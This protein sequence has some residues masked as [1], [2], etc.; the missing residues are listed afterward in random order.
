MEQRKDTRRLAL[1]EGFALRFDAN[2]RTLQGLALLNISYG[3][4]F[5]LLPFLEARDFDRGVEVKNLRF[6]HPELPQGP[7]QGTVAYAL[8][9]NAALEHM[10]HVGI[11]IQFT[12]MDFST[13]H[14]LQAWLDREWEKRGL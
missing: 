13:R 11:G 10:E 5:C 14:A 8:G 3:G 12:E 6:L 1:G 9:G 2:G 4:C 7:I